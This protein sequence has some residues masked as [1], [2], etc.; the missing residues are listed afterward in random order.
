MRD[1]H[2][3]AHRLLLATVR[4]CTE[5]AIGFL[6]RVQKAVQA[7]GKELA[8]VR[9]AHGQ[10]SSRNPVVP[11]LGCVLSGP[12][13]RRQLRKRRPNLSD[14][15]RHGE[16]NVS[17]QTFA[18]GRMPFKLIEMRSGRRQTDQDQAA[19]LGGL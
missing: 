1:L 4:P 6:A 12:V 8:R 3:F 16:E 11:Q 9:D 15:A 10:L 7:L 2:G 5:A 19:C 14:L 17:L 13:K 18:L